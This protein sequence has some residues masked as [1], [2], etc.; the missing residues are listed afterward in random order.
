MEPVAEIMRRVK[1]SNQSAVA[2]DLGVSP[3]HIND[4]IN[5][6]RGPGK[7]LLRALGMVKH[8]VYMKSE[9]VNGSNQDG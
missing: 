2:R 3:A 8:I 4:V 7:K 6:R 5:G 9:I 1:A